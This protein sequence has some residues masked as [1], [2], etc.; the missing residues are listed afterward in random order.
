MN[1]KL[2]VALL[3][4]IAALT[5]ISGISLTVAIQRGK[6]LQNKDFALTASQLAEKA[7]KDKYE[8]IQKTL[9]ADL[10]AQSPRAD[11]LARASDKRADDLDAQLRARAR[12]I[13]LGGDGL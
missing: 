9:A 4:L 13:L 11:E 8:A 6:D 7:W 5:I 12:A 10:V 1:K 2:L 3:C